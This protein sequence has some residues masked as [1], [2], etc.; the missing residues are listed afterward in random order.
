MRWAVADRRD[1]PPEVYRRLALDPVPG[2]RGAVA[3][4]PAIGSSLIRVMAGDAT[5]DV[6]RRLAHNPS[7]PLDVL[8][9][10]APVTRIGATL[11][12]RIAAAAPDEI[13]QLTRSPVAAVRML[14]AERLDLPAA[15]VNILAEDR[16]AKVLKSLA[17]NPML[18]EAQLRTMLARHGTRVVVRVA[19]N[20]TCG[21][22]LLY[23]L[24]AHVPPTQKAYRV[25]AGHPNADAAALMLCLR[26][27]QARPVAARHPGLPAA[28]IVQLLDD[29]DGRVAE[30]AAAN[31]SLARPVMETLLAVGG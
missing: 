11:L 28:T 18:T 27:H 17:P 2:V 29:P 22:G 15:V 23:D 8:A 26:D 13:A 12:P 6:R 14:L 19:R 3:A 4:N 10:I 9:A 7:V 24:A 31:P 1:L 20:P 25:I 21:P 30:A 16:D 5:Y